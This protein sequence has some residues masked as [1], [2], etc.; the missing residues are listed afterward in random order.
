MKERVQYHTSEFIDYKGEKHIFTI[1]AVSQKAPDCKI[2]YLCIGVS[3]CNP[4]DEYNESLG[5]AKAYARAKSSVPALTALKPG[6]INTKVVTAL[7]EQEADYLKDNP[8]LLIKG[9]DD[10]KQR[11]ERNKKMEEHYNS[12]SKDEKDFTEKVI[13]NPSILDK[14]LK[15]LSWFNNKQ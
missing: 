6:I 9:Y 4:N 5:K 10:C 14:I 13:K 12:F 2:K 8:N 7:L 3:I 11:Y 15:Y 1:A